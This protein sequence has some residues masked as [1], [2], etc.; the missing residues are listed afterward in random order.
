MAHTG[1]EFVLMRIVLHY[2]FSAVV[3]TVY[4]GQI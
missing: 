1:L 4:G 3:M 2:L